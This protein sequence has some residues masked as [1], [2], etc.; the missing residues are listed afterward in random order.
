M[1]RR[2]GRLVATIGGLATAL[3]LFV[4]HPACSEKQYTAEHQ[5]SASG[6]KN[7]GKNGVLG[8]SW[9]SLGL[10]REAN[11]IAE[12]ANTIA[13]I[14]RGYA[15]WQLVMGAAGVLFTG[16]AAFFAYRAT[17][18]AKEAATAARLSARADNEALEE[19]KAASKSAR[20]DA[21][22]QARKM[23]DQLNIAADTASAM[24][25]TAQHARE[26]NQL[27]SQTTAS[28][29]RPYVYVLGEFVGITSEPNG[30]SVELGDTAQ[31]GFSIRNFGQ[32]PAKNVA[33]RALVTVGGYWSDPCPIELGDTPTLHRADI[34][35][36][37]QITLE[38]YAVSGLRGLHRELESSEKSIF[39][40]GEVTYEDGFG[41]KY[42]TEFNRALA[43]SGY[44]HNK[45]LT[46]PI[47][48]VAT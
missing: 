13:D 22:D 20:E 29:L 21:A 24:R 7:S 47:G 15:F 8:D 26:A 32:T 16:I 41:K 46:P 9:E 44:F 38:G 40:F 36:S 4:A 31:A 33:V 35:P 18:W 37:H 27:T 25:E 14:Q 42:R 2:Y 11:R 39:L 45:F 3:A 48:N 12:R 6:A 19:T 1:S 43:G 23:I 28:Q 34:P 10:N 30:I 17:H 5:T